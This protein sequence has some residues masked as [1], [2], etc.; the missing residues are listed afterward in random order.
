[1]A[2]GVETTRVL[3]KMERLAKALQD[4]SLNRALSFSPD[5]A[6]RIL[7]VFEHR[8]TAEL[9]ASR[10]ATFPHLARF[11]PHFLLKTLAD[12]SPDTFDENWLSLDPQA[13]PR[14]LF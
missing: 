3:R 9:V 7:F 5:D 12:I 1:M 14:P 11:A 10:A 6:V 8:R 13:D 4:G 2:N